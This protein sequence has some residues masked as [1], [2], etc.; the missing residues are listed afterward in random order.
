MKVCVAEKPSVASEIAKTLGA[1]SRKDGYFEGNGYQVSWVYG[2]LCRLKH[3]EEYTTEWATWK[4]SSLPMIPQQYEITLIDNDGVKK[5]F[6]I[7]KELF[8]KADA[9]IN[10]GDAGQEGE[11]IQR[12]VMEYAKVKCPVY[13]LW[14]SSLTEQSI[15]EGFRNL[16]PQKEYDNLY[17]A[18][19]ARAVGDWLLGIN[20][21]RMYS[22][23]YSVPGK[24]LSIGRVQTPTLAMIVS[25]DIEIEHFKPEPYWLLTTKYRGTLFRSTIGKIETEQKGR[26]MLASID[27]GSFTVTA[28][29]EK[30]G[31][32]LP[33]QLYDLTSL[34]VEC[35]KKY[36]MSADVTLSTIQSLYEK[37]LA[38]YPRVDT[39]FLSD[40]I[41]PQCSVILSKLSSIDRHAG[42][43]TGVQLPKS[44]RVFD[45]AKV[46]DHHAIIPTGE[47]PGTLTTLEQR[48]Y[49]LILRRFV[50]VFYPSCEYMTTTVTGKVKEVDFQVT[51]KTIIQE[52]WRNV[53][54]MSE[55]AEE[56]SNDDKDQ[57][58]EERILPHFTEG[59]KGFHSPSLEQKMTTPPK[60]YTEATLL[61]AMET[62]GKFVDDIELR[63]LMK[64]NGIGRP[65]S[66]AS[67][68]EI[69][70][71]RSYIT[72]EKKNLVSTPTGRK[73]IS[74]ITDK[75]LTSP[76]LTGRWEK[77]LRDIEHG[78]YSFQLF[79]EELTERLR[80]IIKEVN[81]APQNIIIVKDTPLKTSQP[82]TAKTKSVGRSKKVKVGDTCPLCGKGVIRKGPYG[83]FCDQY[84]NGCKFRQK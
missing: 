62:A 1:T 52:G 74:I 56:K 5:Q 25:R 16:R 81:T 23:K 42:L 71:K 21:T 20:C 48:V 77:K 41:Y 75:M 36:G 60:R 76:E 13:R 65:S 19:K 51:G 57:D 29:K 14:I 6:K 38:T 46:T 58:N 59:E 22:I 50:A 30:K 53:Y 15:R 63:E 27:G 35:N 3:P 24:P 8:K 9:I 26:E 33:P 28:I 67:I 70:I 84:K 43:L 17:L 61:Q 4:Q 39:R 55:L 69:L 45:N 40:D 7:L 54:S 34:Q 47:K 12:R 64:A 83:L 68:I 82:S 31:M 49:W 44:K 37:K 80:D 73:L 72:R 78:Q 2:H 10:C 66:R 11:L 79:V 32:E 18:G